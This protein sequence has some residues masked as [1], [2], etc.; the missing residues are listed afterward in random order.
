LAAPDLTVPGGVQAI[1]KDKV[2]IFDTTLRDGEQALPA[3]LSVQ[4]KIRI[5]RQLATLQVDVIEAGFPISSPGDF[6][7]VETI[8][9]EIKGPAICGL[10]RAVEKDILIC[11]KAVKPAERPR[12]HT[13]IGT[14]TIHREKKLRRTPDEI[15]ALV[16]QSV[17]L[18]RSK[19]DDV[20][21]SAEDAGRT[22]PEFL[23]RVVETAI[24][25]GAGTINIPDT[26][27]Y[28][29]PEIFGA[30]IDNL[31]NN[32]PNVDKAII[33]VHC[34]N[35]LGM[36]TANSIT[37]VKHGARQVECTIN[38]IG[39]RAG[40]AA[41]EE[42]VMI[43]KVRKD[44]LNVTCNV[45]TTEIMRT[46]RLVRDLCGMPVQPN[47]AVVGSNA[48]AH[49]SGIHQDGVLKAKQTY[50]IMT[51][52]SIGLKENKMNLT[53]RS[54]SHM[55]KNR[56]ESLGYPEKDINLEDFY[57]RFKALADKKGTIFDDDLVALMEA[58][59]IEEMADAYKLEY[60]NVTGGRGVIPTATVRIVGE[61][62]AK[63]E[64]SSG[65]G[66]V[67]ATTKAIDRIVGF[68]ITV[69]DFHLDS[70]SAGQEAQGRVKI[71]AVAP[72]GTFAGVG[73]ST[74]I[75]EASALAYMDVVNKIYRMRKFAP[76][77]RSR[78]SGPTVSL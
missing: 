53:S 19:C 51:P 35:D 27:G 41:L 72:E 71:V 13:F 12:I 47:K 46:S 8:A 16:T 62:K 37:A 74:D 67:D 61:G 6:E 73:T 24:K 77:L 63:Q 56:L 2:V 20:Q 60:L 7:S 64:A 3:S 75:V 58:T 38:G 29:T 76:R 26:V 43:M 42:V 34:H 21:F 5:A 9:R 39:E 31:M 69:R 11:A 78:L 50:E 44:Y 57:P 65:D 66:V 48:F 59:N 17:K 4:Q 45:A 10:A 55:V 40:N 30:I 52:Q 49:S 22:E 28:T 32:V 68:D 18:A 15:L 25:N 14:S 54:G 33:A 23:C 70:V 1:M 36:A